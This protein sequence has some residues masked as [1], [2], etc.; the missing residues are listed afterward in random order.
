MQESS[1]SVSTRGY[2]QQVPGYLP[3]PPCT[4]AGAGAGIEILG[5]LSR[6]PAPVLGTRVSAAISKE[7][8]PS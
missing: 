6:V 4:G 8:K 2:L 1:K 3:L 7:D 5:F